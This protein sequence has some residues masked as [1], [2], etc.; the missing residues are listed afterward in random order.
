M[1]AADKDDVA[2][3]MGCEDRLEAADLPPFQPFVREFLD[4][5]LGLADEA[6]DLDRPSE[7]GRGPRH[8]DGNRAAAGNDGQ[9]IAALRRHRHNP[10]P[11]SRVK[12]AASIAAGRR[13]CV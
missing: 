10:Q 1:N 13:P 2:G 6:D 9:W 12:R 5:A 7:A 3:A 4:A 8:V 11:G